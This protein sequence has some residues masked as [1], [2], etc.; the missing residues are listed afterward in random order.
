MQ[1]SSSHIFLALV[2][3]LTALADGLIEG[4]SQAGPTQRVDSPVN[5]ENGQRDY[6]G[7]DLAHGIVEKNTGGD[8]SFQPLFKRQGSC[9]DGLTACGT[10]CMPENADCCSGKTYCDAG[11]LC[12]DTGRCRSIVTTSTVIS[13]LSST[14]T[15]ITTTNLQ[16]TTTNLQSPAETDT[17]SSIIIEIIRTVT[18]QPLDVFTPLTPRDGV[19]NNSDSEN[20]TTSTGIIAGATVGGVV[21]GA[22]AMGALWFLFRRQIRRTEHQGEKGEIKPSGPTSSPF[23]YP[24]ASQKG[25]K[26]TTELDLTDL[27]EMECHGSAMNGQSRL[28]ELEQPTQL[29]ELDA[30]QYPHR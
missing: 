8:Y 29:A 4:R 13:T 15:I 1:Y 7:Y 10:G 20:G 30:S 18:A 19:E 25:S 14:S 11:T 23:S 12:T 6:S 28:A 16:S 17:R 2:F 22:L 3:L 21:A 26:T 27:L 9:E 24:E 5:A